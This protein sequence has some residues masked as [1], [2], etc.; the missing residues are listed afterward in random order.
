MEL[1]V[2]TKTNQYPIIIENNFDGLLSAFES[3][4]L[5]LS[6]IHIY[7]LQKYGEVTPEGLVESAMRH[8]KILKE[9]DYDNIVISIKASSVPFS[10][11]AYSLLSEKVDYPLHLGITEAGTVW[12]GTVK[13]AVGIGTIL[14][15]GIG[16]T[17]RV[18]LTGDPVEELTAAKEIRCV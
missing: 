10:I 3:T 18:S 14:S 11:Q 7:I 8:V 5:I 12:S 6:L 16:D 4:G 17:I 1:K 13:S 9:L 2:T 15:M